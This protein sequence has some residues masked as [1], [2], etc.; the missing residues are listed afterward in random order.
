M[1]FARIREVTSTANPT[2]ARIAGMASPNRMLKL[3]PFERQ[4][5]N[6]SMPTP[7]ALTILAHGLLDEVLM[8][9]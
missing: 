1:T 6:A 4:N 8:G 9:P 5:L 3:P 2:A 7:F